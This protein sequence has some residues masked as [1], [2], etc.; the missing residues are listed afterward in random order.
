MEIKFL[1]KDVE[2]IIG[3]GFNYL[4]MQH[5]EGEPLTGGC[6]YM[7]LSD[8]YEGQKLAQMIPGAVC[9]LSHE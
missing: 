9:G 8:T 5:G 1:N 7:D 6:H 3:V 2:H 4:P